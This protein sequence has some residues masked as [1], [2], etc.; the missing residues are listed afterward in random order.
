MKVSQLKV[1]DLVQLDPETVQDK[2]FAACFMIV[3]ELKDFEAQEYVLG[4]DGNPGGQAY[5]RATWEEMEFIGKAEWI[6]QE[7]N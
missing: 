7:E 6:L 5:Y 4:M 2:M 1:G 3:T